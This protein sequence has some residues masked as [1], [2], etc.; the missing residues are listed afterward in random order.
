MDLNR[1]KNKT[2]NGNGNISKGIDISNGVDKGNRVNNMIFEVDR[3]L[4][5]NIN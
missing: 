1:T 4:F 5:T 3:L 2:Y